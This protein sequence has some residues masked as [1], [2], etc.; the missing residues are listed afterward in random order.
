MS[1]RINTNIPALMALRNLNQTDGEMSGTITRL[2]TGLRINS[3]ADDAA[4]LIISE[5]M[6]SQLKGIDQAIR[7]SQDAV[8]MTKTAEGALDEVQRLLRNIRGLA[9]HSANSAV[10]DSN[11]LQANQTQIRSTL[12]SINRI[13]EQTQFGNKKLLDGSAGAM[14][15]ITNATLADSI[16]MSGTFNGETVVSGTVTIAQTTAADRATVALGNTFA[17]VNAIVTTTGTFVINGYS[18]ASNGTESVQTMVDK[19]N[20]MTSTT[21]VTAQISG[22]GPVSIQLTNKNYGSHFAVNYFDPSN[23]LHN[24]ASASDTG[25]DG[26]YN[27]S[28][29][30]TAGLQTVVFQGGR[31]ANDSG[32]RLTDSN[33]NAIQLSENGNASITTAVEVGQISAGNVRFQIGANSDQSVSFSMPSIYTNRLGT[34]AVSGKTLADLDVTTQQGAQDAMKIID[35][36]ISQLALAR[37]DIGSFQS[38]FLESTVRSLGVAQENLTA[39]ESQIR[40]ADMASEI[41]QYT[42]LQILM[43]SGM[44]VLAQAS[45]APQSVLQLLRGGG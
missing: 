5:G 12:Q 1:L 35:D 25:T 7:N 22:S 33:G 18:F 28:A 37:G 43:Q 30:T 15:N 45:Q 16:Y 10:V 21:G 44:S 17:D 39:S 38:N 20:A 2:S 24:A 14:A 23:V 8:N 41:T 19:I 9:V 29:M 13:A 36:A 6:R 3:A 42:R 4:G 31:G 34:N 11:T 27:V 26:V 32:L 40:D